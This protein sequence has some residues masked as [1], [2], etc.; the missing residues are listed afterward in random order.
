MLGA[1]SKDLP[2]PVSEAARYFFLRL[3]DWIEVALGDRPD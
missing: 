1:E 3:R 2:E